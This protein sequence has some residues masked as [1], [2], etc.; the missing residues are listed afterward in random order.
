MQ[1]ALASFAARAI[2]RC[3]KLGPAGR[4]S[5]GS[6]EPRTPDIVDVGLFRN[7]S[8]ARNNGFAIC[9][10]VK[11]FVAAVGAAAELFD[12]VDSLSSDL[13][14]PLLRSD[15]P[16]LFPDFLLIENLL[17]KVGNLAS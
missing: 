11:E 6:G 7:A 9:S 16:S 5:S 13:A 12:A 17:K 10:G 8:A 4:G 2:S 15:F 1:R 14:V 3:I